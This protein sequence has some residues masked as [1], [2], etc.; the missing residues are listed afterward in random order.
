M[1]I[2]IIDYGSGNLNSVSKAFSKAARMLGDQQNVIVTRQGKDLLN[3][4]HIVLPGVG[5]FDDCARNLKQAGDLWDKLNHAVLKQAKPFLGICVGEQLMV[6]HGLEGEGAK[7]LGWIE[8]TVEKIIPTQKDL[9]VP[10]M[11][12][13]DIHLHKPHPVFSDLDGE[14]MYFTHSWSVCNISSDHLLADCDYGQ[15][16]ITAI[17]KDN[18][19]GVQF[20]PEKS[21]KSGLRLIQNFLQWKI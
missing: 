19:L 8:G 6:E 3:A 12:W 16:I 4:S 1:T 9:K 13:N 21:Q 10:H 7:G 17:G 2:A 14:D 15:K 20:H 5:A 18:M 11:G